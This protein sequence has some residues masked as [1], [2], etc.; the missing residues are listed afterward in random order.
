MLLTLCSLPPPGGDSRSKALSGDAG[1][2]NDSGDSDD[3]ENR[4]DDKE[5]GGDEIDDGENDGEDDGV[6][7]GDS[8]SAPPCA[9]IAML[10]LDRG[11]LFNNSRSSFN[12]SIKDGRTSGLYAMFTVRRRLHVCEL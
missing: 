8:A 10:F 5:N 11:T 4:G 2:E 12:I 7:E 9:L 1:G 3:G 6:D